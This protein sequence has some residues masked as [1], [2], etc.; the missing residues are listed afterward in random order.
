MPCQATFRATQTHM[1]PNNNLCRTHDA[2]QL[3]HQS[4]AVCDNAIL[5]ESR[6][7]TR[8]RLDCAH[9]PLVLACA[10]AAQRR[11]G[12]RQRG[13]RA[14]RQDCPRGKGAAHS[15]HVARHIVVQSK[16]RR[17]AQRAASARSAKRMTSYPAGVPGG[18]GD[19]HAVQQRPASALM[20]LWYTASRGGGGGQLHHANTLLCAAVLVVFPQPP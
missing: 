6:R 10:S 3:R 2:L 12:W 19:S 14:T 13:A 20:C 11:T 9:T 5:K 15:P 8:T 16:R 7:R 1:V 18:Q 4:K 17:A